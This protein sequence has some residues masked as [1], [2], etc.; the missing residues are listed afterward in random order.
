MKLKAIVIILFL[1]ISAGFFIMP[2]GATLVL[3]DTV[4][5]PVTVPLTPLS[6]Q[7]VVVKVAVLPSGATTFQ[8]EHSLQMQTGLSAA[9]WNIQVFEN[10]IAAATQAASGDA[11]FVNGYL[12][13][14][15]TNHDVSFVVTV[16]GTVPATAGPEVL[17]LKIMELDNSGS[18]VPGSVISVS[19][20]VAMPTVNPPE[21]VSGGETTPAT[22]RAGGFCAAVALMSCGAFLVVHAA[23]RKK[24]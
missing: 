15:G 4:L 17:L 9:L 14:Y 5:A 16:K 3:T 1:T 8:R 2:A 11:A 10:G 20:P 12:L 13:S 7:E 19:R 18:V 6:A 22:T 24:K 21:T 23:N